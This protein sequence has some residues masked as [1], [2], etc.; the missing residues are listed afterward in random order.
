MHD[1]AKAAIDNARHSTELIRNPSVSSDSRRVSIHSTISHHANHQGSPT[2]ISTNSAPKIRA[3]DRDDEADELSVFG[4]KTRLVA[5]RQVS[6]TVP[7]GPTVHLQQNGN[8]GSHED[9]VL[10][11]SIPPPAYAASSSAASFG[12]GY[13]T[14]PMGS[15][16]TSQQMEHHAQ[17][18][19]HSIMPTYPF[20]EAAD[21]H[22][23][24]VE[25]YRGFDG[26]LAAQVGSEY[27]REFR[28]MSVQGEVGA[29]SV[30]QNPPAWTAE[31]H[32]YTHT[33]G[34]QHG[35][36]HH[37]Q[38][39]QNHVAENMDN[40]TI[41]EM[42]PNSYVHHSHEHQPYQRH[43]LRPQHGQYAP[44][45][46]PPVQVP[47]AHQGLGDP[48]PQT[49]PHVP[50]APQ[51]AQIYIPQTQRPSYEH[52]HSQEQMHGHPQYYSP[53][54][55]TRQGNLSEMWS[56]FVQHLEVP[57]PAGYQYQNR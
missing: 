6:H 51:H 37:G 18:P 52:H 55:D 49:F 28:G 26:L 12:I 38:K 14:S 32:G 30:M 25:Q 40:R 2:T 45:P 8:N 24:L 34:E 13:K 46:G 41:D 43:P 5:T 16:S 36:D 20:S 10:H 57:N 42:R 21:V 53:V 9:L 47:P 48:T 4:G 22:P 17:A 3:G 11:N 29:N 35:Q 19:Q 54:E 50:H 39:Y 7:T 56:T 1:K 33:I 44:P 27:G 15:V 31:K 23:S